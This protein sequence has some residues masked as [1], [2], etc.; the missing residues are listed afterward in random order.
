MST[1]ALKVNILLKEVEKEHFRK[2]IIYQGIQGKN[3]HYNHTNIK[4]YIMIFNTENKKKHYLSTK[5]A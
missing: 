3:V 2:S 5:S 4:Q 1:F